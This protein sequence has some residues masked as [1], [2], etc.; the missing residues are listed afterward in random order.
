[1]LGEFDMRGPVRCIMA[2]LLSDLVMN[3]LRYLQ[4]VFYFVLYTKNKAIKH[5][6]CDRLSR[7]P[8][9]QIIKE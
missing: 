1:M 9:Q 8:T 2:H 3:L 6:L 5:V 7:L 4:R